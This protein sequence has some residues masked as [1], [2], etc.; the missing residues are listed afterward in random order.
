MTL[1]AVERAGSEIMFE[2]RQQPNV[3]LAAALLRMDATGTDMFRLAKRPQAT[4]SA[5]RSTSGGQS[6]PA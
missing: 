3:D 4:P 1:P 2:H 6:S 5:S